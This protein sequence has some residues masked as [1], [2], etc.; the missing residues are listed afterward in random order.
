MSYTVNLVS[1]TMPSLINSLILC[2]LV[3]EVVV[4]PTSTPVS[5]SGIYLLLAVTIYPLEGFIVLGSS[6]VGI[7]PSQSLEEELPSITLQPI[8]GWWFFLFGIVDNKIYP[9]SPLSKAVIKLRG[10]DE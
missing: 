1:Y 9:I 6:L 2:A 10:A 3:V 8:Y 5:K 4:A 7:N